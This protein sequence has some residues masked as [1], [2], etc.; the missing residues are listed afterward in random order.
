[1]PRRG[2]AVLL[3]RGLVAACLVAA[4]SACVE[5][6]VRVGR[7]GRRAGC[8][9]PV[10]VVLVQSRGGS[11]L[12]VVNLERFVVVR[13]TRL[14]SLCLSIDGDPSA[15]VVAT[16]QCGGPDRTADHACGV[17]EVATGKVE[18]V[19]LPVPNPAEV[20]VCDGR[21]LLVH[22]FE[23]AGRTCASAV[24][25]ARR[26][27]AETLAL[28][29]G[30]ASPARWA[31]GFVAVAPSENGAA[32]LGIDGGASLTTTITTVPDPVVTAVASGG[33]ADGDRSLLACGTERAV[34][35][36]GSRPIR[37]PAWRL[38]RV[39]ANGSRW[40]RSSAVAGVTHGVFQMCV[41]GDE[42]AL[43]DA[44]GLD[45]TDPGRCVRL[46][47]ARAHTPTR[48]L[49]L[50]GMPA[51]LAAWEDRLLVFDGI[52]GELLLFPPVSTRPSRRLRL[53]GAPLGTGDLVI[54]D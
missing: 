11:E 49:A 10:A 19:E 1:M 40:S 24:D 33:A 50:P 16:A 46:L 37:W 17:Y 29:A 22:G 35:G 42:V 43:A 36:P 54:F 53:G 48:T 12:V 21:A 14:R 15:R 39:P 18:Y 7:E 28:P 27:V 44:D 47:D 38:R 3:A 23:Q 51:A 31:P 41:V 5:A 30:T 13:R 45:L 26:S 4:V 34:L 52:T 20:A 9:G 2:T 8:D 6:P 25:L 32:M